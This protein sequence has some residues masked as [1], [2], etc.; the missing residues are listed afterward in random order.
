MAPR[1]LCH[2]LWHK[3]LG[4]GQASAKDRIEGKLRRD[5]PRWSGNSARRSCASRSIT[6]LPQPACSC[7]SRMS[8]PTD[9][10][11]PSSSLLAARAA[12]THDNA[13]RD[14]TRVG[15]EGGVFRP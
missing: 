3:A 4:G 5:Q 15:T 10:Y 6:R 11:S 7:R 8:R 14:A 9:Q 12:R 13:R 1:Q 2:G